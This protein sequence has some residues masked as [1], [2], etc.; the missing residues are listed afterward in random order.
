[1][2]NLFKYIFYGV[3]LFVVLY[4]DTTQEGF[5]QLWKIP[6]YII[7]VISILTNS[8]YKKNPKYLSFSM[9]WGIKNI[10]NLDLFKYFWINLGYGIKFTI[11]YV[12]YGYL[13]RKIKSPF[14][15]FNIG[16]ILSQYIVLSSI[17]FLL[18]LMNSIG[19]TME[20]DNVSNFT[21]LFGGPHPLAVCT[22]MSAC[23]ILYHV[24]YNNPKKYS[25][26]FNSVLYII[27]IVVIY[28]AFVRTGW[29]M[30]L[31]GSFI[32]YWGKISKFTFGRKLLYLIFACLIFCAGYS[33]LSVNDRFNNRLNDV[34]DN[35]T[36][37]AER[38]SG[39]I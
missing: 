29:V 37:Q 1:M 10:F 36:W 19:T 16:L 6:L 4:F 26:Y 25:K 35:G 5:S 20:Y 9:W 11:P 30:F 31:V 28:K 2:I 34:V 8:T 17:P 33:Y 7:G 13:V 15:L 32:V 18:G 12:S 38:G 23:F 39:R 14:K 21:G 27:S 22:S 24:L 3:L